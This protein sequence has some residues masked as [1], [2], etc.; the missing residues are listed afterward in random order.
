MRITIII[1]FISLMGITAQGQDY[2]NVFKLS[3]GTHWGISYKK[4]LNQSSGFQASFQ[5]KSNEYQL[6]ALRIF[7]EPAF[8]ATSSQWFV[9]YGYGTHISYKTKIKAWNA[10]RPLAPSYTYKG[11]YVSPG[12]DGYAALEYRFLKFPFVMAIEYLPNFEFLGP[13]FFRV[14]MDNLTFSFAYAF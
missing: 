10:F 13:N 1:L 14:N 7:H 8:P 9:G 2:N 6:T 5:L 11:N 4:L 3:S 12:F